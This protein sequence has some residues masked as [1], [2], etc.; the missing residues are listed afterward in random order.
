MRL[1]GISK[2]RAL[3]I[4]ELDEL[5][6]GG[7]VR[8]LDCV[9]PIIER[10]NFAT[11]PQ[12]PEDFDLEDKGVKFMSGKMG[13]LAID[14]LVIYNGALYVDTF[15]STAESQRILEGMLEW[16]V[17]QFG[18]TYTRGMIKKWGYISDIVFYTDFP[19][20]AHISSPVQK[21]SEKISGVTERLWN[22]LKYEPINLSIG[23]DPS[24]RKNSIASFFIQHR[25]NSSFADN[26]YFS[27]APLPTD[28]HIKFIEEFEADTLESLK[29]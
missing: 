29:P 18:L 6:L 24:A 1:A 7:K 12:K 3:A 20:L 4:I 22:G 23:H 27:E 5:S 25:I 8:F 13:D 2:A 17:E 16:G 9:A 28:L 10:Y 26:K 15:A 21:L 19:L 11:F 14:S